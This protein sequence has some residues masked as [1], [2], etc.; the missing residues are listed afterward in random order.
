MSMS[1]RA[2]YDTPQVVQKYRHRNELQPAEQSILEIVRPRLS[3][4]RMLD[5]GV[6]AGRTTL[7][8][9][10]RVAEYLGVDYSALMIAACVE[11]FHGQPYRFVVADARRLPLPATSTFDF[12]LFSYNGIDNLAH[13]DRMAT[14]RELRRLMTTQGVLAF[15]SHNVR[16]IDDLRALRFSRNPR[17]L[18]RELLRVI[19]FRLDNRDLPHNISDPFRVIS[20]GSEQFGPRTYYVRPDE[21]LRQLAEAGFAE[22]RVFSRTGVEITGDAIERATDAWLY[23]LCRSAAPAAESQGSAPVSWRTALRWKRLPSP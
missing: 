5:L 14:L 10:H 13:A 21:Q 2:I 22:V 16:A 20:D 12:V 9:A 17:W 15:S 18:A 8:F 7:H 6:G 19:R 4:M 11:R 1:N 3:A 23:Y